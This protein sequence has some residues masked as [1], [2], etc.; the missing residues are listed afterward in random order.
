MMH[1]TSCG[2]T[3]VED[4]GRAHG[5]LWGRNNPLL[6]RP[7]YIHRVVPWRRFP[8]FNRPPHWLI[9]VQGGFWTDRSLGTTFTFIKYL[10]HAPASFLGGGLKRAVFG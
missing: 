8:S 10:G 5:L 6:H 3:A 4:W 9:V 7:R 2:G 1:V